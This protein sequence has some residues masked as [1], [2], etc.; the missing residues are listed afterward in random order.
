MLIGLSSL[1]AH[2]IFADL[3]DPFAA[4]AGWGWVAS[5][6]CVHNAISLLFPSSPRRLDR[7][8]KDGHSPAVPGNVLAVFSADV[9][10]ITGECL[11]ILQV[12]R[13]ARGRQESKMPHCSFFSSFNSSW[14]LL[15]LFFSHA[16]TL[17]NGSEE[18]AVVLK[19]RR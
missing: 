7:F 3:H 11:G 1:W 15:S 5:H 6:V 9:S 4:D 13:L 18:Q 19:E 8:Y 12:L 14:I 10:N 2:E 16:Q 17:S